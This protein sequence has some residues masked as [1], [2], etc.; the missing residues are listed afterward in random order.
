MDEHVPGE[1]R[2][3]VFLLDDHEIIRR[4]IRE[5]LAAEPDIEVV[6]EAETASSALARMRALRPDV[7]VLDVRLPDGDGVAVCRQIRSGLPETACLILTGYGDDRALLGAI[8]AGAEGYV[9]KQ[10]CGADLVRAVRTVAAGQPAL[11]PEA[12]R[13]IMAWLR[14]RMASVDPVAALSGQEKQVLGL[15]GEGRTNRQIAQRLGLAEKTVANHVSSLMTKLGMH[16]RAQAAAFAAR[17]ADSRSR[18]LLAGRTA[19]Q[20]RSSASAC[21]FAY[22]RR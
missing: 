6:G 22:R 8:L 19:P 15:I 20:Q 9:P 3:R 4:G 1:R 18:D 12:S 13:L 16:R 21:S 10:T 14:E 11:D 2:T 17:Q 5:L 7:A